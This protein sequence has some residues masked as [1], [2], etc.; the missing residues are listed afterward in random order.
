MSFLFLIF[1][2]NFYLNCIFLFIYFLLELSFNDL[3]LLPRDKL[4]TWFSLP[5]IFLFKCLFLWIIC[6]NHREE[7]VV[8]EW[9]PGCVYQTH[10]DSSL[11]ISYQSYYQLIIRQHRTCFFTTGGYITY[12]QCAPLVES[13]SLLSPFHTL[14]LLLILSIRCKN[15]KGY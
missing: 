12:I 11:G 2:F 4:L 7:L 1:V 9:F 3:F 5:K 13:P 8:S 10:G 15:T 14:V 6:R